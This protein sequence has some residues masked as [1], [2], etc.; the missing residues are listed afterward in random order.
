MIKKGKYC[1]IQHD[2]KD[3]Q[4]II[5]CLITGF[6]ADVN[7][8]LAQ[9]DLLSLEDELEK[10]I[11]KGDKLAKAKDSVKIVKNLEK[12]IK[13]EKINHNLIG[14]LKN[15]YEHSEVYSEYRKNVK[16]ML[17]KMEEK[18]HEAIL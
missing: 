2:T 14:K 15:E 16:E 3:G 8:F 5:A 13:N 6:G 1:K 12:L 11:E 17:S 9:I 10:Y 4:E 7:T 18:I